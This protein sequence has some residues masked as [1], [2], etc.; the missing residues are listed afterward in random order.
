MKMRI[1]ESRRQARPDDVELRYVRLEPVAGEPAPQF[2]FI[3]GQFLVIGR[4]GFKPGYFAIA[5]APGEGNYFDLLIRRGQGMSGALCE[6]EIG[7]NVE[8]SGPQGKGFP[9]E[10]H[11]GKNL[12][13][14]GVGTGIAPLRSVIRAVSRDRD[15][16]GRIMCFYGVLTPHHLCFHDEIRAWREWGVETFLTVTDPGGEPWHSHVG[17]VQQQVARVGPSAEETVAMLVGMPEM[18]QENTELLRRL[19]FLPDAILLNY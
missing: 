4:T 14:I 16:Y 5:S 3:P 8:V 2:D 12:L 18:I 6:L 9:L 1:T 11:R 13:L 19:G 17:F 15:R 7:A 10:P